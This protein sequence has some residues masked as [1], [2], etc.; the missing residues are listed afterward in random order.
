MGGPAKDHGLVQ[1]FTS[2]IRKRD[3]ATK[4][5]V[6]PRMGSSFVDRARQDAVGLSAEAE[7]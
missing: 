6:C 2:K 3:R 4:A 7:E 5:R 1:R